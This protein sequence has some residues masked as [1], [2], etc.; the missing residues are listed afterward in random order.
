MNCSRHASIDLGQPI[1]SPIIITITKRQCSGDGATIENATTLSVY[2]NAQFI[3]LFLLVYCVRPSWCSSTRAKID[4][5]N[6]FPR[7]T[8]PT[9]PIRLFEPFPNALMHPPKPYD[10]RNQLRFG[11]AASISTRGLQQ[12]N[13]SG[14]GRDGLSLVRRRFPHVPAITKTLLSN[15]RRG[16]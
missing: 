7:P 13:S 5:F 9:E 6:C 11:P 3:V 14:R 4:R 16:C 15:M 10:H 1:S 12:R 8:A 2:G